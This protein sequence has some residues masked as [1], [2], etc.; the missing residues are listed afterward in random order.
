MG[1]PGAARLEAGTPVAVRA[2]ASAERKRPARPWPRRWAG[3]P[4]ARKKERARAPARPAPRRGRPPPSTGRLD[5]AWVAAV[6]R[7]GWAVP[8]ATG[9]PTT[10]RLSPPAR[11]AR[12]EALPHRRQ[13][14]AHP[15]P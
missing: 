10:R 13:R 14:G 12:V 9:R 4:A 15:T 11:S 6:T 5:A 1:L 7:R 3:A 8:P 2:L